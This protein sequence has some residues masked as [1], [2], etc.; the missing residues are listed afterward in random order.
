MRWSAWGRNCFCVWSFWCSEL[1]SVD[2][3]VTVQRGSV[4]DVKGPEWFCQSFCSL[5]MS[6]V[7]GDWG[8]LYQ[9]F[10]RQSG[11]PSIVF[12]GQIS[13]EGLRVL[14]KST[15]ISTDLSVLRS[16]LLSWEKVQVYVVLLLVRSAKKITFCW[17]LFY[18]WVGDF[19]LNM[20]L[21]YFLFY[22]YWNNIIWNC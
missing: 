15:I 13:P 5:W 19:P 20:S 8:G 6:T 12:W 11:L 22:S 16:R 2:Q 1:C 21:N 18:V 7:L 14:L 10:A 4:L 9:W 3:T 17:A